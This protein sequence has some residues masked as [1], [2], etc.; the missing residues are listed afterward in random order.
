MAAHSILFIG[1]LFNP[2]SIIQYGGLTLL[3]IIVFAETGLFFGFFLPGDSLLFIAGL[4]TN[5]EYLDIPVGWL[6]V[7]LVI[8][9]SL[10]TV[11]GFWFGRWT[12]ERL[13]HKKESL[14]Y[15]QRYLDMAD[16]FYR[17]Y[18]M[19]AF[20]LGRFLPIIRTFIPILSGMVKIP[21][22]KF[23]VYNVVGAVCWISSMVL[24]GYGLGKTFPDILEYLHFIVIGM[25]VITAIPVVMAYRKHS[26]GMFE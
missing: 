5:S 7:L 9:A 10:G 4:L 22:S 26:N 25:V 17:K 19:I 14:F 6:V 24:A 15:K 23:L 2:Q 1:E 18:G 3:L 13:K 8:S 20:I 12:G 11:V 21:F 16:A